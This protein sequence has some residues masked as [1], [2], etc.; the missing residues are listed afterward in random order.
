MTITMDIRGIVVRLLT[1][2][3]CCGAMCTF[4][5]SSD[6]PEVASKIVGYFCMPETPVCHLTVDCE[7][8]MEELD[9]SGT[10]TERVI[11]IIVITF[12]D[13]KLESTS[14]YEWEMWH[15]DGIGY[16]PELQYEAD[17]YD[18]YPNTLDY[19]YTFKWAT[20]ST[21]KDSGCQ[22]GVLRVSYEANPYNVSRQLVAYLKNE[23]SGILIL[24][25]DAN[26]DGIYPPEGTFSE[27]GFHRFF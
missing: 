12:D 4:G 26:P 10:K 3:L 24:R 21:V 6:S 2:V 18:S 22:H 19:T 13:K 1:A 14:R 25:Q 8:G 11:P 7:A 23:D 27:D 9:M 16:M 15:R 5:C 20:F 17:G